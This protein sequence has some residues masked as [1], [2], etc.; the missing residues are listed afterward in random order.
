MR[1]LSVFF[2]IFVL[3]GG[4]VRCSKSD[5]ESATVDQNTAI[6]RY[7]DA[8]GKGYSQLNGV[9]KQVSVE[10]RQGAKTLQEGDSLYI[11]FAQYEFTS[12][13]EGLYYTNIDTLV[14]QAGFDPAV[15]STAPYGIRYGE[16][17]LI[18]GLNSGLE[19]CLEGEQFML[20]MAHDL[21]YGKTGA[22]VVPPY[23]AIA[24]SV[25]VLEIKTN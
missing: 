2:L 22:G 1:R 8:T 16:T 6:E 21:A 5:A 7:L 10:A 23:T 20:Y 15:I 12:R 3:C 17:P 25:N 18:A 4:F 24:V 14:T 13:P 19:G 11:L 9:Y